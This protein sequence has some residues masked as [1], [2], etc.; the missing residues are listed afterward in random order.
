MFSELGALVGFRMPDFNNIPEKVQEPDDM[1]TRTDSVKDIPQEVDLDQ[2]AEP[3]S[4]LHPQ[5][6]VELSFHVQC[7]S[8]FRVLHL[9]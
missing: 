3:K 7:A 1:L 5:T 8:L 4:F 9:Q 2:H 6:L